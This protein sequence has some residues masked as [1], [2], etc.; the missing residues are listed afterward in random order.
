M[1]KRHKRSIILGQAT[2]SK[3]GLEERDALK[4]TTHIGTVPSL[5]DRPVIYV[6]RLFPISSVPFPVFHSRQHL[7]WLPSYCF[8]SFCCIQLNITSLRVWAGWGKGQIKKNRMVQIVE[9]GREGEVGSGR[10][11]CMLLSPT[12]SSRKLSDGVFFLVQG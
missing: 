11:S 8:I 7:I 4:S 2:S 12:A 6:L 5:F 10:S 1:C 9:S 3:E